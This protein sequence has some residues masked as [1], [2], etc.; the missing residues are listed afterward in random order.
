MSIVLLF[1][2]HRKNEWSKTVMSYRTDKAIRLP[3]LDM[4][5]KDVGK[6]GQSF[7]LEVGPVCFS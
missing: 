3:V 6:E 1:W 4:A 2:Q 5:V 7:W